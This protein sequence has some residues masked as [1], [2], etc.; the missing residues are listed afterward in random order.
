MS[1]LRRALLVLLVAAALAPVRAQQVPIPR[2]DQMPAL[3]ADYRLRDWDAVTRG[4]DSLIFDLSRTG[5]YLPLAATYGGTVNYPEHGSFG[6][7]TYVGQGNEIPGEAITA[8]PALV[9]ATWAGASKRSQ[10]GVDWVL[11]AEQFFNRRPEENVYLNAP[12]AT[13]GDDWWYDTMPNVFFYQLRAQYPG[14]GEFD[15]QFRL[16]AD[17]W[18]SAVQALGGSAAPWSLPAI[19]YRGFAL[20]TMTPRLDGVPEP[21]A[22][23]A[24]GWLLYSA[25]RETGDERYRIG[26]EQALAALERQSQN[27]SYELQLPY[28]TLAAARMN[29]EVGTHFDI[30]KLL[31]WSFERGPLRGWGTIANKTRGGYTL[32]GLVGE[33]DG[34]GYAFALNGFQQAAALV[35]VARYDD[36]FARAIGRWMVNLASASRLF[37]STALPAENQDGEDWAFTNDP[38]GLLAYE[39]LRGTFNGVSPFATGDALR[40][41]WAPTNLSLYSSA[42][43]GY[44][45]A[46]VDSTEVPGVLRLDLRKT[47]VYRTPSFQSF[48]IYNPYDTEQTVTVPLTFGT[49]DVYDAAAN[50][51]LARSVSGQAAVAIP[52]DA[53][54]VLV[55]PTA[56]G[57]ETSV[58]GRRSVNGVVIDYDDGTG[59][60]A[61]P[62]VRALVASDTTLA[63]DQT[64]TLWCTPDDAETAEPAVSWTASR[65][66][67]VVDG[68]T[69]TWSSPDVGD[70]AITCTASDGSRTGEDTLTLR[71]VQN[72]PPTGAAI[73]SPDAVDVGGTAELACAASDPDGDAL[74]YTWTVTAGAVGGSGAT[75]TFAAP[76]APQAVT[77]TCTATDPAGATTTV[78]RLLV[79]GRLILDLGL[80]GGADDATVFD[81]D[82][83]VS[84][85]VPATGHDG[86]P[87][88]ALAFDGV[89]DVVTIPSAE[90][91]TPTREVSVSVW[92]R[93]SSLPEREMFVVSHGSWQNRWKLSLTPEARP[94]WTVNTTARIV[95]LDAPSPV[96]EGT[97]TH[98]VGTYDGARM[99][100]YVDGAL[101]ADVAQDGPIRSTD[102]PLLVGQ[103]LP[104]QA[105]FN[106]PG[107]LD[108]V[109]VYN[110]ALTADEVMALFAGETDGEGGPD[111]AGRLGLPFPNPVRDRVTLRLDRDRADT[112]RVTVVDALGRTVAVLWD[113]PLAP[114]SHALVWDAGAVA[115][116]VYVVRLEDGTGS[117]SRRVLVA[118]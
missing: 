106:F 29:A 51:F 66:T 40:N 46:V 43:V 75:T 25:Y 2:V 114:G 67:L 26:A 96:A 49:Y 13:S 95:D 33:V 59:G 35:P 68:R 18:L 78:S 53:A 62:R 104:G 102:L 112:A 74:S 70:V 5:T 48:L 60:N 111:V 30:E 23:G 17:Q 45:A 42:S 101:A 39:A 110:K 9:G 91:L 65:G 115:A 47:D 41:N 99:R 93:P 76:D 118:R 86:V 61:P 98:L 116:G 22:A 10:F 73:T 1:P 94:R 92:L 28:G 84:G 44:L 31:T 103:M 89:D 71:V 52:P 38:R 56:G 4:A 81:H 6:I 117:E 108:D 55:F 19:T 36:R 105:D 34:D 16:V 57:A 83:T 3:P 32:D 11:R 85:A 100:L 80:D 50:A 7:E 109:R 87:G 82:G 69:A 107:V 8:L 79:V 64:A 97:F 37:Y 58:D 90:T 21:E 24:I 27:P 20:S 77:A 113:G 88:H 14:V 54:R 72:Q 15:R 63:R 12:R